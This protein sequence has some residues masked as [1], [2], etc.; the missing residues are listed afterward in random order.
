[1]ASPFPQSHIKE[2]VKP[3]ITTRPLS[4]WIRESQVSFRPWSLICVFLILGGCV[5]GAYILDPFQ[6]NF[7]PSK[8]GFGIFVPKG[9]TVS[10]ADLILKNWGTPLV[11]VIVY[12]NCPSY[13]FNVSIVLPFTVTS[14]LATWPWSLN[15]PPTRW[16]LA[17]DGR[18][19]SESS[20][21]YNSVQVNGTGYFQTSFVVRPYYLTSNRGFDSIF[22]QLNPD[23]SLSPD[24]MKQLNVTNAHLDS[25]KVYVTVPA[26]ARQIQAF[27]ETG[28]RTI[29]PQSL[30][31]NAVV[32]SME[33][34]LTQRKTV[35]LS[36]VDANVAWCYESALIVG[37]IMLGAAVSEY[38]DYLIRRLWNSDRKTRQTE[39]EIVE[40]SIVWVGT[41]LLVS[42]MTLKLLS[43]KNRK[44]DQEST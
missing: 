40:H 9:I 32:D 30:T 17:N 42:A 38:I 34:D 33:W 26:S 1:M 37:S 2:T 35:Y 8:T 12:C 13:R 28:S 43:K 22:I 25:I 7:T 44:R 19:M 36:Y 20:V 27:P 16:D 11:S 14:G 41:L 10:E 21:L 24:F 39:K 23:W 18:G 29:L 15:P 3:N 5:V 31:G 6:T 4:S